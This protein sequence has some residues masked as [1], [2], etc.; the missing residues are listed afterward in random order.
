MITLK[1]K[2]VERLGDLPEY[3]LR[4]VLEFVEYLDWKSSN[5]EDNTVQPELENDPILALAGT[6]SFPPLSNEEIDRELYGDYQ[7]KEES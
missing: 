4:E 5:R 3:S 1:D 6:L 2:I 7:L